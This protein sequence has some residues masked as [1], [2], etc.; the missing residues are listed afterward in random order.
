MKDSNF[1]RAVKLYLK[2]SV[3]LFTLIFA[4][5]WV[6]VYLAIFI[7]EYEHISDGEE[8]L[9]MLGVMSFGYYMVPFVFLGYTN[10][11]KKRFF[12]TSPLSKYFL[13]SVPVFVLNV[14]AW[15]YTIIMFVILSII[16]GFSASE[17]SDALIFTV[18]GCILPILAQ[19]LAGRRPIA[20]VVSYTMIFVIM[21]SQYPLKFFM[22]DNTFGLSVPTGI[23]IVAAM[24]AVAYIF[25]LMIM[26]T[27]YKKGLKIREIDINM[28]SSSRWNKQA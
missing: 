10:N 12:R 15:V 7:F 14:I 3:N 5:I 2:T 11:E 9:S 19:C 20:P 25:E 18:T 4:I 1:F 27:T 24:Y 8:Y 26:K 22:K 21:G 6:G 17:V 13:T 23:I 28:L 16:F